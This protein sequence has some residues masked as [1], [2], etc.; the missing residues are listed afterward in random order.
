MSPFERALKFTLKWEGGYVNDPADPGGETK[1]GISKRAHPD[2]DI[3]NLTEEQAASIYKEEYWDPCNLEG[4]SDT[5]AIAT[6][7]SAVNCGVSRAKRWL[8]ES[9]D[10][11]GI[12]TK[13][14][15]H[16]NSIIKV[17]PKLEKFRKGWYN[18]VLSLHKLLTSIE[19]EKKT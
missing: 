9:D 15:E 12:L 13:R 6:F 4:V 5:L 2:V 17:N 3:K 8:E 19:T 16:Y 14:T 10:F 11:R 7:D 18:R 1:W